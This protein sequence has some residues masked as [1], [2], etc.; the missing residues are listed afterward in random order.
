[1]DVLSTVSVLGLGLVFGL[2]HALDADH[3]AAVSTIVSQRKTVWGSSLVGLL[4][5]VG[6]T[7]SL[8]AAGVAVIVLRVEITDR[9]AGVLELCVALMLIGLGGRALWALA[10]GGHVHLHAHAHGGVVHL[11]PHVHDVAP[12]ADPHTHHGVPLGVQPLLVGM[13]HGLAGSAALML[14]VLS[15][16]PSAILGFAYI[17]VFGLGSIGGMVL[18]SAL[19]SLP[20]HLT[21]A[22]FT[23]VHLVARGLAGA[24]SLSC[25]L[26]MAYDIG[27]GF[28]F[29]A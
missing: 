23:R 2:K 22:R 21:A 8:L 10:R 20:V 16:I 29:F 26:L 6:H 17:A 7:A 4:W 9:I 3:L 11:H 25:G 28:G 15:T 27:T 19:V 24:F 12:D 1:M 5:G 14:L 13:V 18:M